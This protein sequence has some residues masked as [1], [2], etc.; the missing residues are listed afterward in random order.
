VRPRP[1]ALVV[2]LA[3]LGLV[4]GF[5]VV[6]AV[7]GTSLGDAA[8]ALVGV[9]FSSVGVLIA[10][11]RRDNLVG[12]IFLGIGAS[13]ALN[14]FSF[15]YADYL[16]ARG[17]S[18]VWHWFAWTGTWSWQPGLFLLIP[19]LFLVFPDGHTTWRT[20]RRL[21]SV[22]LVGLALS[23]I[24]TIWN[25]SDL[26]VAA[27][28]RNP[29]G[30]EG[31]LDPLDY[32]LVIGSALW[33]IPGLYA[34]ARGL[35]L[36]FRSAHGAERQQLKWFVWAG[37]GTLGTYITGSALYNGFGSVPGGI[38]ALL[39]VPLLP[40][41]TGVA[42][43]RYRLFDIDVVINRTLVYTVLTTILAGV[44]VGMVFAFQAILAPV[45]SESD[46]AVA[47]STLAVAALF[48]PVRGRVQAF[49]DRRF[50][51]R[52]FDAQRTLDGFSSTLR[53]EVDLP[54]LSSR[55]TG[56]VSETMQPAH[57]SLWLR[58]AR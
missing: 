35:Y 1:A 50:Y 38:V 17:G 7:G 2:W 44:Y 53:D 47:A 19:T 27:G 39:G 10:T 22:C 58:E 30:L 55:L 34:S 16:N 25:P 32:V 56:V 11:R 9:T 18:D 24:G 6:A 57:L 45:T 51:R 33:F 41:A 49:I 46:L 23:L 28:Y 12:W 13:L 52:K 37:F 31:W 4:I 48:R 54:T 14:G 20:G 8:S 36:R 21:L 26:P 40:V 42:I 5:V 29:V 3:T 43:L 15:T